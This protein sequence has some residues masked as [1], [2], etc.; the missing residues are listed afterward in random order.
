MFSKSQRSVIGRH[1]ANA[2]EQVDSL[3]R[4]KKRIYCRDWTRATGYSTLEKYGQGSFVTTTANGQ[5]AEQE[6]SCLVRKPWRQTYTTLRTSSRIDIALHTRSPF[7]ASA[8]CD[9][10]DSTLHHFAKCIDKVTRG[11]LSMCS[12]DGSVGRSRGQL[13]HG[14]VSRPGRMCRTGP[15]KI[16]NLSR[17]Q[18]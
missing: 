9:A 5:M 8:I 13:T 17:S 3:S 16:G 10:G 7:P 11:S 12:C 6:L 2:M 18:T 4:C 15:R 14:G 1:D